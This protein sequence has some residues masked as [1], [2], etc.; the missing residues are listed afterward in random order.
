MSGNPLPELTGYDEY[1]LPAAIFQ[2]GDDP[3]LYVLAGQAADLAASGSTRWYTSKSKPR[4][5]RS[6]LREPTYF[7]RLSDLGRAQTAL[8]QNGYKVPKGLPPGSA[9]LHTLSGYRA[10]IVGAPT[11]S[12]RKI[13][14]ASSIV[15]G[16]QIRDWRENQPEPDFEAF[17]RYLRELANPFAGLRVVSQLRLRSLGVELEIPPG[18]LERDF[19]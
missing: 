14:T 10:L 18:D 11:H 19:P 7:V 4:Q 1:I 17:K 9:M 16:D 6:L 5:P 3:I 2:T 8:R 13:L 15:A 12:W